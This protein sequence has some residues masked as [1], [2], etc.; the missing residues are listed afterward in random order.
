MRQL[1]LNDPEII[2]SLSQYNKVV[3]LK[4]KKNKNPHYIITKK[5][6]CTLP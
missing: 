6:N 1:F 3:G 2:I 4:L 5:Q